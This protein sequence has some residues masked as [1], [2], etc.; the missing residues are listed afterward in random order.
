MNQRN[1]V[2]VA[3]SA[4]S[5]DL[6][7]R[8]LSAAQLLSKFA[9]VDINAAIKRRERTAKCKLGEVLSRDHLSRTTQQHIENIEFNAGQIN[10]VPAARDRTCTW[11]K[12]DVTNCNLFHLRLRAW[13]LCGPRPTQDGAYAR[14]KF[15]RIK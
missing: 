13:F 2:D 11:R 6:R 4:N 9:H 8:L 3:F 7:F 10:L 12:R 1:G 5:L 15:A 14:E